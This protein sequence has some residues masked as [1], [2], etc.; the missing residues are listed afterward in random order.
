MVCAGLLVAVF[1]L[2]PHPLSPV[3]LS[4]SSSL[5][6]PA[7]SPRLSCGL[8]ALGLSPA[9]RVGGCAG[10]GGGSHWGVRPV[11][12]PWCSSARAV[13]LSLVARSLF[14]GA[15]FRLRRLSCLCLLVVSCLGRMSSGVGSRFSP[16]SFSVACPCFRP[17]VSSGAFVSLVLLA[18][19]RLGDSVGCHSPSPYGCVAVRCHS[20]LRCPGLCLSGYLFCFVFLLIACPC[21][22]HSPSSRLVS[23]F[24]SPLFLVLPCP[25]V[26]LL[27][28]LRRCRR[29]VLGD[30]PSRPVCLVDRRGVMVAERFACLLA[31]K[32]RGG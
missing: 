27:F 30:T 19:L 17:P 22:S 26:C 9:R 8:P 13:A 31:Y 21:G 14:A 2:F 23:C 32:R 3:L 29:R 28:V 24:A 12:L 15:G 6:R 1:F 4:F 20:W 7:P 25:V 18:C 16:P 10:Y 11:C 5:F